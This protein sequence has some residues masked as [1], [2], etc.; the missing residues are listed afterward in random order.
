MNEDLFYYDLLNT[1]WEEFFY[2]AG[3]D[4]KVHFLTHHLSSLFQKHAPP[5][6]VR[7]NKPPAPWLTP[8]LEALMRE[9]DRALARYAG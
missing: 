1:N 4:D 9:R 2:I 6:T 3:I 7:V 5:R 8:A